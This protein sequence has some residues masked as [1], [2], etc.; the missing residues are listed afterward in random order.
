MT[1]MHTGTTEFIDDIQKI[2]R[3]S[4]S[5]CF[6]SCLCLLVVTLVVPQAVAASVPGHEHCRC[7]CQRCP[8]SLLPVPVVAQC[9]RLAETLRSAQQCMHANHR[10]VPSSCSNNKNCSSKKLPHGCAPP[11]QC[12]ITYADT[13]PVMYIRPPLSVMQQAVHLKSINRKGER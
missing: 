9:H 12:P 2:A 6:G 8:V 13:V 5:Q 3:R 10:P 1:H 4:E 7:L 11:T